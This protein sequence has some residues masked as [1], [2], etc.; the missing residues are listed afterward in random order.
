MRKKGPN[1]LTNENI[2]S[3]LLDIYKKFNLN[4]FE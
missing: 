1:H 4:S 2:F 3:I